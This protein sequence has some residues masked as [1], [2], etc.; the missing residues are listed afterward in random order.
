MTYSIE[1]RETFWTLE[2][3]D[4]LKHLHVAGKS[5][6]EIAAAFDYAVTPRQIK[7]KKYDLRLGVGAQFV[8]INNPESVA[9]LR[10]Q[11]TLGKSSSQI[12]KAINT[13]FGLELT[14]NA[15]IGKL[16]R[17]GLGKGRQ[18]GIHASL[19]NPARKLKA[20]DPINKPFT[21]RAK[22]KKIFKWIDLPQAEA[23]VSES[24]HLLDIRFGQCRYMAS[25]PKDGWF[26]GQPTVGRCSW[27]DKHLRVVAQ[28]RLR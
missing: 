16:T 23:V 8:W 3:L 6:F 13:A 4:L 28:P 7:R 12:A 19:P 22:S 9:M 11:H 25:E 1:I 5:I 24:V 18:T 2:H 20:T 17:L 10:E 15:I 27:C 14:R 26:C 21:A